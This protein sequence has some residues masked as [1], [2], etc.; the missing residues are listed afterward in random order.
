MKKNI[1][2]MNIVTHYIDIFE[3]QIEK[4]IA[5]DNKI[6]LTHIDLLQANVLNNVE[7]C[8]KNFISKLDNWWMHPYVRYDPSFL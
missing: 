8:L 7:S 1:I 6:I 5:K 2:K 3:N 4:F